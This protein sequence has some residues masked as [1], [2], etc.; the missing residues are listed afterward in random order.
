MH[1]PSAAGTGL[2]QQVD[3]SALTGTHFVTFQDVPGGSPPGINYDEIVTSGAVGFAERF[4]GQTLSYNGVF[5]V[6]SGAGSKPLML[7]VGAPG[8]NLDLLT[9]IFANNI[10]A[11]LG[12]LGYPNLDA[13]GEGAVAMLFP[14]GVSEVGLDVFGIDGGGSLTITFFR[15]DGTLI[16]NIT[17]PTVMGPDIVRL[18]FQQVNGVNEISGLTIEN[19]D[20]AG[21]GY[22]TIQFG[23]SPVHPVPALS[24]GAVA[25]LLGVLTVIAAIRL[26]DRSGP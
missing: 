17:V 14:V 4:V 26:R 2:I 22:G 7:E 20:P 24:T 1:V 10:L 19:D 12:P 3:P 5:D 13:I 9:D 8:Q 23:V 15:H 6:L 18:A 16:D 25:L 11:G 21:L